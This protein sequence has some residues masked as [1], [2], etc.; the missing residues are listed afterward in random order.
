MQQPP[1]YIRSRDDLSRVRPGETAESLCLE[2]KASLSLST[3]E[4]KDELRK[5]V[6]AFANAVGGT[7]LVG[8]SES[9]QDG[10]SVASA[11]PG[12]PDADRLREQVLNIVRERIEPRIHIEAHAIPSGAAQQRAIVAV[13]VFPLITSVAAVLRT[14]DADA[15]RFW[16]RSSFGAQPLSI[17]EVIRRMDSR[18]RRM[19]VAAQELGV[20]VGTSVRVASAVV[21][22]E[23]PPSNPPFY[24]N[25]TNYLAKATVRSVDEY[26]LEL[27]VSTV[28][29]VHSVSVPF[30]LVT[31]IWRFD[32]S[33]VA[34]A[35]AGEIVADQRSN[36][37]GMRVTS[38]T[39]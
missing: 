10:R 25:Q 7:M 5:D 17:S 38:G 8:V 26:Q 24:R 23:A 39:S 34:I 35:I 15:V 36:L 3:P 30:E 1:K 37:A 14:T 20:A 27:A 6:V 29:G 31:A 28:V 12:V 2:F 21:T 19:Q 33:T 11:F 4:A 18:S 9:A 16:I 22:T 13:N 32:A